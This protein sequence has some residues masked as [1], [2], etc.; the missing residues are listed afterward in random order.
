[1]LL[2][3]SR[4]DD[5]IKVKKR[6]ETILF[7][8]DELDF[9]DNHC[10]PYTK[11]DSEQQLVELVDHSYGGRIQ[12]KVIS[13]LA[14]EK[15]IPCEIINCYINMLISSNSS[16]DCCFFYTHFSNT[17]LT[18]ERSVLRKFTT[19]KKRS[20]NVNINIFSKRAVFVPVHLPGHWVLLVIYPQEKKVLYFDSIYNTE[21]ALT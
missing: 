15:Q 3:D 11:L 16:K 6:F 7:T 2:Y 21:Y 4:L 17:L 8:K 18:E 19:F 1:M 9:Y 12:A 20:K 5:L 14:P 13:S 10:N